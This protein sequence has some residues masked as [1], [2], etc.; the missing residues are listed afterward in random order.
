MLIAYLYCLFAPLP[1]GLLEQA[2][3][4]PFIIE[5]LFKYFLIKF[6]KDINKWFFPILC[7]IIFSISE[8]VF[9]LANFFQLGNFYLFPLRLL[10]TT[11]L[12]SLTFSLLFV[13]KKNYW[14]S[15]LILFL[16]III[17]YL[18]NQFASS[19]F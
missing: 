8:S 4:Y 3:P 18:Y 10:L 14:L 12:H 15:F 7:G 13:V 11:I 5:E 19:V 17:H 9:Y 6:F 1:L 16:S 2:L